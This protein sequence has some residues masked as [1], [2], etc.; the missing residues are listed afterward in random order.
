MSTVLLIARRYLFARKSHQLVNLV[1]WVSVAGVAVGTFGLI[2]VLSVFNGFGSLVLSLYDTFD[3]DIRIEAPGGRPFIADSTQRRILLNDPD[4]ASVAPVLDQLALLRYRDQQMVVTLRGV[5]EKYFN[6]TGVASAV[7]YGS[8]VLQEGS[9]NHIIPGSFIAY[10]LGLR[11]DDPFHRV[12]VIMPKRGADLQA[13]TLDPSA[14]FSEERLNASGV[15]EIQQDFDS[16]YAL[17]PL[18]F[19]RQISG[20]DREITAYEVK[21]RTG[22]DSDVVRERLATAMG[23]D[24]SVQ[25]RLMQHAFLYKILK[26]EKLAV[27][28]ILGFILV[29]AA[30]NLFGTLSMLILEKKRDIRILQSMGA[31]WN[32]T[33]RV[34]LIEG[35]LI[36]LA[37][38][39]AG[40][41]IGAI[42]CQLQGTFGFITLGQGQGF[43]TEAYPVRMMASDFLLVFLIATAIG[44]IASFLV[45]QT[46]VRRLSDP[47]LVNHQV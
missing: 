42:V 29:I 7:K 13:S 36:S 35:L 20:R 22:A 4:V 44:F 38:T 11:I 18:R 3:P 24:F 45:S 27:Y 23:E 39:L 30:F 34:F 12:E 25:D 46:L 19:M 9:S 16:K 1:S 37:G 40:L 31:D 43:V 14:A 15:F 17:V 41:T 6:T 33:R 26:G 8:A 21:L 28:L 47:H 2:V 5:D 10:K 32:L